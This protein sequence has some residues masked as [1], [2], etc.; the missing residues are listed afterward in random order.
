VLQRRYISQT[1]SFIVS[2]Q[3]QPPTR[4]QTGWGTPLE[5]K[6]TCCLPGVFC[7]RSKPWR[8][9]VLANCTVYNTE[10]GSRPPV[11][12]FNGD[13]RNFMPAAA[14]CERRDQKW[15]DGNGGTPARAVCTVR[16]PLLKA[17][18]E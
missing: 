10:T 9:W 13:K 17:C 5:N 8:A 14:F 1:F 11:I 4:F 7:L 15:E 6:K 12:H 16:S 18:L 2:H 3:Q